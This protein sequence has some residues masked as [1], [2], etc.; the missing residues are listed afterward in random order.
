MENRTLLSTLLVTSTA[1]SGTGSLRQAILDS[2]A[3]T[4]GANIIDFAIPGQGVQ[5]IA[6]LS[7]LPPITH[8]V[9]IDGFSQ[10]GYTGTPLIELSGSQAGAGRRPDDHRFERH[11]P[12]PGHRRLRQ[13][14]RCRDLGTRRRATTGSTRTR[15][16]P[17]LPERPPMPNAFG[18]RFRNGAHDNTIGTNGDGVN[19]A[20]EANL[21]RG[22]SIDGVD[23]DSSLLD[24]GRGFP[25]SPTDLLLSG[26]AQIQGNRLRLT[27]GGSGEVAGAFTTRMLDVRRFSTSFQFQLGDGSGRRLHLHHPGSVPRTPWGQAAVHLA[28]ARTRN[29]GT[30]GD[31][32]ERRH[33][34]RSLRQQRRGDRLDRALP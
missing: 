30:R 18:V 20:S 32:P 4:A 28:T 19:D 29:G 8:A 33:Q 13:R 21:I 3:A 26:S 25:P 17:T 16:A 9:L 24:L 27:D 6:P 1:D 5:T 2:N 23:V 31:R 11:G 7:A 14:R 22:N 12:R 10:P 34:V 15:S